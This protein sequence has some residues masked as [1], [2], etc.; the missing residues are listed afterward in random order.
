MLASNPQ[1]TKYKCLNQNILNILFFSHCI[2]ISSNY[3]CFYSINYKLKNKSNKNYKKT[4][5]NNT[6]LIHYVSVTKP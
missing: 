5:T 3:N 1:H 4:I 2:F 6:K